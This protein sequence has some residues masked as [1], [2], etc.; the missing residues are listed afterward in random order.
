M[1][2]ETKKQQKR[3]K[4]KEEAGCRKRTEVE[5]SS[6]KVEAGHAKH[7]SNIREDHEMSEVRDHIGKVKVT[8]EYII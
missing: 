4:E 7:A 1:A 6:A 5:P 2:E 8:G 3:E